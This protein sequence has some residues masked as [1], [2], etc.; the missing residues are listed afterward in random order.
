MESRGFASLPLGRFAV[1]IAFVYDD[2]SL[3]HATTGPLVPCGAQTQFNA[4]TSVSTGGLH[5]LTGVEIL[6]LTVEQFVGYFDRGAAHPDGAVRD[7]LSSSD[8]SGLV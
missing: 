7:T 5:Q 4:E 8:N 3:R 1:S 2:T 6:T